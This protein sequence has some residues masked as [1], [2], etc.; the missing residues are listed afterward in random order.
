[1]KSLRNDTTHAL[2]NTILLSYFFILLDWNIDPSYSP[3]AGAIFCHI[4]LELGY[5]THL[6]EI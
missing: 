3:S 2:R 4:M 1:M 5:D 6:V